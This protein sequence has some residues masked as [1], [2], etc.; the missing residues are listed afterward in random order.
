MLTAQELYKFSYW[1]SDSFAYLARITVQA[2]TIAGFSGM[3][4]SGDGFQ[5]TI[6]DRIEFSGVGVHCGKPTTL[7]IA[8]ADPNT[9]IVFLRSDENN[10][11]EIEIPAVSGSVAATEMC[12]LLGDP[13]GLYVS[14]VEHLLAALSGLG[15]D[16]AIIEIDGAEVPVLDGSAEPFVEGIQ[17]VGVARQVAPRRFIRIIKP[18]RVAH[19]ESYAQFTPAETRIF[20]VEIDFDND[21]IGHQRLELSLKSEMFAGDLARA[22]TFGF[23]K[24]VERLWQA[25]YAL[26]S[27]LENTV[28]I[29]D[30]DVMNLEGLRYPDEFVRHKMLDA[31]G[32]LALAGLPILGR[33]KSF[34]GGHRLNAMAVAALLADS[35]AYEIVTFGDAVRSVD[36]RA[37]VVPGI[38]VPAFAPERS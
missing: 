7:C 21:A 26:G 24:D 28:V 37:E 31:I 5:H 16:N 3:T 18:V 27:S 13:D 11:R 8:P 4:K 2:A 9:G 19:K 32:D 15:V 38:S 6:G 30:G 20:E 23:M 1:G 22:R 25:G 34:K 35:Q 33:Y 17:S 14:T 12:T 29:K 10:G 36:A